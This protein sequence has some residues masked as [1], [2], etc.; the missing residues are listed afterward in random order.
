MRPSKSG[1]RATFFQVTLVLLFG[2]VISS[3]GYLSALAAFN[4]DEVVGPALIWVAIGLFLFSLPLRGA[5]RTFS[6]VI[7]RPL[8]LGVFVGYLTAHLLLYGFVLDAIFASIYGTSSLAEP[9]GTVVTTNVFL[10]PS[11]LSLFFDVVYNPSIV[12]T[13]PPVFGV[14]FSFYSVAI[15][16]I[17]AV[18]ILANI[19]RAR[20]L[21]ELRTRAKKARS[22]VVLPIVGIVLG[23]S[24]CLSVAGIV[25]LAVPSAAAITSVTWVYYA[26]YFLFPCAAIALLYLNLHSVER[27]SATI[28]ASLLQEE[29]GASGVPTNPAKAS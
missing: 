17:I 6:R 24:C 28:S 15:A 1:R 23:A 3:L 2:L 29:A 9:F 10:P 27:I 8:G 22:Y 12:V 5:A 21:G 14:A 16:V 18:L 7:R 20:E 4:P 19:G 25:A 11:A 13:A 26:T